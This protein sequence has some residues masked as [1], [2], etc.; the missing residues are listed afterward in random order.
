MKFSQTKALRFARSTRGW[1]H[2]Y[3]VRRDITGALFELH[4]VARRLARRA[5]LQ[6][7]RAPTLKIESAQEPAN[8]QPSHSR[9]DGEAVA[10]LKFSATW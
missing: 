3:P 7:E 1:L 2:R 6:P 5:R 8:L 9:I 4:I 10:R